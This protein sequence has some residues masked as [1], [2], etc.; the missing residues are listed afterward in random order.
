MY[1]YPTRIMLSYIR[2]ALPIFLFRFFNNF[3]N[4]YFRLASKNV[5]NKI[6][7]HQEQLYSKNRIEDETLDAQDKT[8]SVQGPKSNQHTPF[9]PL[10]LSL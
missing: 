10:R 2:S 5:I 1:L 9:T 8:S 7:Q 4:I 6:L 3:T